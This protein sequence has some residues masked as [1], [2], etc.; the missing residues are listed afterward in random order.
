MDY[1]KSDLFYRRRCRITVS[2][3][4]M[5]CHRVSSDLHFHSLKFLNNSI[6]AFKKGNSRL[7]LE[8]FLLNHCCLGNSIEQLQRLLWRRG[9]RTFRDRDLLS[10]TVSF[11]NSF[12][13]GD[14]RRHKKQPFN[15]FEFFTQCKLNQYKNLCQ[16]HN[17]VYMK[18]GL[19]SYLC[20]HIFIFGAT[21]QWVGILTL[22][23]SVTEYKHLRL[24]PSLVF[25]YLFPYFTIQHFIGAL[26]IPT[27][28]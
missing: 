10:R 3:Q 1:R 7:A 11:R 6:L 9:Y 17:Q 15:T 19:V 22:R 13:Q 8:G 21:R 24:F 16:I 2:C 5:F 26:P 14:G 12:A 18:D 25:Y 27:G 23:T 4:E 28:S 20:C